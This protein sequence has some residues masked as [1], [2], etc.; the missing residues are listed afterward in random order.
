MGFFQNKWK[1][2]FFALLA[3]NFLWD[4]AVTARFGGIDL[5]DKIVGARLL[6]S[7]N[8]SDRRAGS[9]WLY[10]W[11]PGEPER[12][13][14]P[15]DDFSMRVNRYTGTP[16]QS[17]VFYP[18]ARL[19]YFWV[20]WIWLFLQYFLV[21]LPIFWFARRRPPSEK[22][23]APTTALV[24][25]VSTSN[26]HLHTER[27]QVYVLAVAAAFFFWKNALSKKP[28]LEFWGGFTAA[29]LC[30]FKP[31]YVLLALPLLLKK[32]IS[33]FSAGFL[34]CFL[35]GFLIFWAVGWLPMWSEFFQIMQE[36]K[37]WQI[38]T[39][40]LRPDFQPFD[41]PNVVE[42]MANLTRA[43]PIYLENSSLQYLLFQLGWAVDAR[44]YYL[45]FGV[46]V[47]VLVFIFR[48]KLRHFD[49]EHLLLA[50]F[51]LWEIASF[52]MP[53][54]RNNYQFIHW[55][56]PFFIFW[57]KANAFSRW[58]KPFVAGLVLNLGVLAWLP[59]TFFV[60]EILML[61]AVLFYLW[62]NLFNY[63]R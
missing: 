24:F 21:L 35:T 15:N 10:K 57:P 42:G 59:Y 23:F 55:L 6:F 43:K 5:R 39:M 19:P 28:K 27:G 3:L 47:G 31:V 18:L 53:F 56:L 8:P 38:G 48:K 26:W 16:F 12:L 49:T 30:F 9:Q 7:E 51:V 20:R 14:I 25:F 58:A 46:A 54:P 1:T 50:G 60:G 32:P 40:P 4:A 2:A 36:W 11:Q 17:L 41:L 61:L 45:I 34:L 62:D 44:F 37:N 13:L 52:C 33:I 63:E 29:L 22:W